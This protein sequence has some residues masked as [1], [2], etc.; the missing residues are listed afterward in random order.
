MI[1]AQ[2]RAGPVGGLAF[3]PGGELLAVTWRGLYTSPGGGDWRCVAPSGDLSDRGFGRVAVHPAGGIAAWVRGD[4]FQPVGGFDITDLDSGESIVRLHHSWVETGYPI[5][6][7]FTP[8]GLEFH[9]HY[10]QTL[11]WSVPGW[12]MLDALPPDGGAY[13]VRSRAGH[14]FAD[15]PSLKRWVVS[16]AAGDTVRRERPGSRGVIAATY[17]PDSRVLYLAV[18][19]RVRRL[20]ADT[21]AELE[22]RNWGLS[23]VTAL[24]VGHDGLTAAMGTKLGEVVMWDEG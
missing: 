24:A 12:R 23:Q 17:S 11:R 6:V 2:L 8:D 1:Q 20:D 3:T 22:P 9:A 4:G 5:E 13:S 21:G 19:S 15:R 7:A 16:N 14:A 18:N 10:G